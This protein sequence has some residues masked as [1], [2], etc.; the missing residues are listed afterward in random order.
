M[1]EN[2]G[3]LESSNAIQAKLE[4]LVEKAEE[5]IAG[6]AR[7]PVHGQAR[8]TTDP[9]AQVAGGTAVSTTNN[10]DFRP[11][12]HL[13][14]SFLEKNSSHL[15]VKH[16]CE[17][18]KAYIN[19]GYRSTPPQGAGGLWFHVKANMHLSLIHI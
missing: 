1:A 12:S 13:K 6:V 2:D 5:F 18:I 4:P 19:T 14:P 15:E 11:H 16:F 10:S 3:Y 8:Q 17:Q 7:E 9:A